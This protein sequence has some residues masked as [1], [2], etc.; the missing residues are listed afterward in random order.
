MEALK[1]GE[2]CRVKGYVEID[3]VPGNVHISYH[4]RKDLTN[5]V[6]KN[7]SSVFDRF[8]IAFRILKLTIGN[9]TNEQAVMNQYEETVRRC[10]MSV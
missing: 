9:E 2:Q 5:W 3:K 1:N 8:N 6:Q 4:T 7:D 10:V